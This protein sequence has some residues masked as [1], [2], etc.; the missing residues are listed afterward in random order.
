MPGNG[1]RTKT[2]ENNSDAQINAEN[3]KL[4][5]KVKSICKGC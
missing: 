1:E 4:D 2:Q 5:A 3:Q